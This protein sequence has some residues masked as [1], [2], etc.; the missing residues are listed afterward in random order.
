MRY[1]NMERENNIE[2]LNQVEA[3]FAEIT[4]IETLMSKLS[5]VVKLCNPEEFE[6]SIYS[7][8]IS[9]IMLDLER[10]MNVSFDICKQL[11][12]NDIIRG[13][14]YLLNNVSGSLD[15]I[16]DKFPVEFYNEPSQEEI[17]CF[18]EENRCEYIS[19]AIRDSVISESIEEGRVAYCYDPNR[20]MGYEYDEN[21]YPVSRYIQN[22]E[23]LLSILQDEYIDDI[24][25]K[26]DGVR[27]DIDG[28][29]SD[30]IKAL[31]SWNKK[32]IHLIAYERY[33]AIFIKEI[34]NT[35]IETGFAQFL[36][37]D[38]KADVINKLKPLFQNQRPT[39]VA[40][41]LLA[42]EKLSLINLS[43][44][45]QTQL[46]EALCAE[47]GMRGKRQSLST[48]LKKYSKC[49]EFS[50]YEKKT[51]QKGTEMID[52]ILGIKK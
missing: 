41:R 7:G 10:T 25:N 11:N 50:D 1:K 15:V 35:S 46:H 14:E 52:T 24:T 17:I 22:E 29:R 44:G 37:C 9:E 47:F 33:R 19:R 16:R 40:I 34:T 38:N 51:V 36:C 42:L 4:P 26:L 6:G 18:L 48:Q 28:E 27:Q 12:G 5:E 8:F 31:Y 43:G 23:A 49:D 20:E 13:Y 2:V 21:D 3:C 39:Q 32:L 45:N 30:F